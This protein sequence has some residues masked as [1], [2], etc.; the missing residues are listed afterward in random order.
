M[1]RFMGYILAAGI[2]LLCFGNPQT[3]LAKQSEAAGQEDTEISMEMR[4]EVWEEE[5]TST[6]LNPG[7]FAFR[8][9]RFGAFGGTVKV[10]LQEA[11]GRQILAELNQENGYERNLEAVTGSYCVVS[12]E[13]EWMEKSYQVEAPVQTL[14]MSASQCIL[15]PLEVTPVQQ[16]EETDGAEK[17]EAETGGTEPVKEGM[18]EIG[19]LRKEEKPD[20]ETAGET[21]KTETEEVKALRERNKTITLLF[22]F[23]LAVGLFGY[24]V[25]K[26]RQGRYV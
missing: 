2:S 26:K 9:D 12:A 21:E 17:D 4:Q 20:P 15:V 18:Q 14:Q 24:A 25:S 19:E 13:A 23:A 16:A 11:G 8:C 10:V 3:A 5:Y 22:G 6:E 7:K 1:Q